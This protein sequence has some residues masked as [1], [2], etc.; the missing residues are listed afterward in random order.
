M[1]SSRPIWRG[2]PVKKVTA[3]VV[4][5]VLAA[6]GCG[7]SSTKQQNTLRPSGHIARDD[8]HIFNAFFWVAVAVGVGVTLAT[9]FAAIKFRSRPGNENPVQT[10]GNTVLEISWTILP[11]LI[12]MV[13]AVF[14]VKMIW[15]QAAKPKGALEITVT[16]KQW[17]WEF[18]YT[19]VD[20]SHQVITANELHIPQG[21]PVWFTLKS[22]NV[23]HSFWIPS[24]AGKK[25]VMPGRFNHFQLIADKN[26]ATDGHPKEFFG[27]CVEYCGLSHA[28]MRN[29]TFVETKHDF[30]NWYKTQLKP[31]TPAQ[32]ATFATFNKT[33]QC[34][35]CHYIQGLGADGKYDAKADAD[36]QSGKA[37]VINV[38][39][40]LTHLGDR[41]SF[42]GA[43]FDLTLDNLTQWVW[44]APRHGTG[45]FGKYNECPKR[46]KGGTTGV[47]T[48]CLVGMPSFKNDPDHPMSKELAGQIAQF[49]LDTKTKASG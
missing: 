22:D 48:P 36:V 25:D 11:A 38:G 45:D 30:D 24:L 7:Q 6:A 21:V 18:Q 13:M 8:F 43:S 47:G 14:T 1:S 34:S 41:T 49:L 31:W 40:N 12:L 5:C 4:L 16:G 3:T 15:D 28:D 23:I 32:F 46:G 29:R 20:S 26:L 17:W 27:Q 33:Y 9:L 42:G 39:P 10:H 35:S 44:D 37:T 19:N 2:R